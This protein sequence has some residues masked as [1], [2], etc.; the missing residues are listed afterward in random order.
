MKNLRVLHTLDNSNRGG[1]QEMI[2]RLYKNSRHTIE[3]WAADGSMAAEMRGAGMTLWNGGPPVGENYDVVV[4]H[5][6]GGWSHENLSGWAKERKAKFVECMHSNCASPTPPACCDGFVALSHIAEGLNGHMPGTITIYG[7]VEAPRI[8]D[9]SGDMIGRLSRLVEEKRPQDFLDLARHF[10]GE[11]FLLAGEG[12][13]EGQLRSQNLPNVEIVPWVRDYS[14]FFS[15]LKLFVFPTRDECCCISV[16]QAQFS[17]IPV[18]CQDIHALRETTGGAALYASS[19]Q[20]FVGC[21]S[22]VLGNP[23]LYREMGRVGRH[24]AEK[25]FGVPATVGAW[26]NYVEQLVA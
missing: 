8:S 21:V 22:E 4:G 10:E 15:R 6:V 14:A 3:F 7:V 20:D 13:Q 5:T 11:R 25:N 24:W 17:G 23:D 2:Y 26:D 19:L 1:I 16:A 9:V 18:I 12:S